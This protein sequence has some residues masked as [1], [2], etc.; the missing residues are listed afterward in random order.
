MWYFFFHETT[1]TEQLNSD[2]QAINNPTVSTNKRER[3]TQTKCTFTGI[4]PKLK[5]TTDPEVIEKEWES[6]KTVRSPYDRKK[7][8][9]L[10]NYSDGSTFLSKPFDPD[11]PALIDRF[12]GYTTETDIG[13][14]PP[15]PT[16]DIIC[17]QRPSKKKKYMSAIPEQGRRT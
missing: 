2:A 17:R 9:Y 14:R 1:Q 12:P 3:S 7:L 8:A 10:M 16:R 15:T 11:D 13:D 5:Q 4:T 6:C